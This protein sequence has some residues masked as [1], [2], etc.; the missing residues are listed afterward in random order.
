M[1]NLFDSFKPTLQ[2]AGGLTLLNIVPET[3]DNTGAIIQ[4]LIGLCTVVAQL[5]ALFRKRKTS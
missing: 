1:T 3:P 2:G 4:G 5:I